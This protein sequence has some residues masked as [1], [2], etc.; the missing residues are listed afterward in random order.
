M[1]LYII[2]GILLAF[3]T[4]IAYDIDAFKT[5]KPINNYTNCTYFDTDMIGPEDMT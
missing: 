4:K 3:F 1:K 2:V 5:L